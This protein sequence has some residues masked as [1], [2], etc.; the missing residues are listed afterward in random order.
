MGAIETLSTLAWTHP[1]TFAAQNTPLMLV[2]PWKPI[3]ILPPLLAWAYVVSSIYDKD[4]KRWY[5]KHRL[6][7][8]AH[9]SAAA[10]GL[11]I[12]LLAPVTIW[13]TWPIMVV[14]LAVDIAAYFVY[15]NR[16]SQVPE[17]E[18]WTLDFSKMAQKRQ[19]KKKAAKAASTT[20]VFQGPGGVLPTPAKETA[21][22]DVRLAAEEL[23]KKML[24][25]RASQ[26]DIFP[27][28]EGVYGATVLV[29]GL[30]HAIEQL[31]PA[32]AVAVIDLYKAAAGLDVKD[33]RRRQR[34]EMKVGESGASLLT[35]GVTTLGTSAGMRIELLVDPI[36]QVAMRIGD[37][38]LHSNQVEDLKRLIQDA[39]G[40]VLVGAMPDGGRTST[41][42]ALLREHDAYTSNVQIVEMETQSSIEGVRHNVFDPQKDGSEYSTLVR[43]ILRRDPDVVGVAELDEETAKEIS[44]S[45]TEHTRVYVTVKA[46]DP[47]K[48]IQLFAQMVA[49]QKKAAGCLHGVIAVKLLRRLCHNCKV[50]VQ[51]T[52]ESLKKLGLPPDTKQ[53][54]RKSGKVLVKD[55]EQTCPVC[56][57]VGYFGQI[58]SF[59]V[60]TFGDEERQRIA[61]NDLTGLRAVL[62]QHK[63][64]SIQ[65]AA[66]QHV[67]KGETS[68]E[69]VLR[70]MAAQ[71]GKKKAAEKSPSG[72]AAA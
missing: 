31:P 71:K 41:M 51:P 7:N 12:I 25:A 62:R 52:P 35:V 40:V 65:Q 53:L 37:L 22:Y 17:S 64:Q 26:M 29:D 36:K 4:A 15:H 61:Q 57:G 67:L 47:L 68:V 54:F 55:K 39:K 72:E 33:R 60:H 9:V 49:D 42:Y 18:R 10:L 38:G 56:N 19:Q 8:V 20:L 63:Q 21:D 66:L 70:I 59:A 43:S 45:D 24:D 32:K 5:F 44:R 14:I 11:A 2:S 50:G 30:R 69:E 6:W 16:H 48:A 34:G 13:I 23:V 27:V 46:D 3:L 28:K 1:A 58:G